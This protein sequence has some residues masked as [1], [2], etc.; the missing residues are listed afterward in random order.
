MVG[1]TRFNLAV[2]LVL[3]HGTTLK[4]VSSLL[5]DYANQQERPVFALTSFHLLY[6]LHPE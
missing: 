4:N 2:A 6:C 3:L 5:Q 1:F